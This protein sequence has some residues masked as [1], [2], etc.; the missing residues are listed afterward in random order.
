MFDRRFDVFEAEVTRNITWQ[1]HNAGKAHVDVKIQTG[2]Q[3][4]A[5]FWARKLG[6]LID[7]AQDEEPK[8]PKQRS[9]RYG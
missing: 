8:D 4:T 1:E 9:T 2:S 3:E 7:E 5:E 6:A